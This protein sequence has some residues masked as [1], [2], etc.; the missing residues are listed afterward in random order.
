M[1]TQLKC[2]YPYA[3]AGIP[4]YWLVDPEQ[5]TIHVG[6]LSGTYTTGQ[7]VPAPTPAGFTP[8]VDD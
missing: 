5:R 4:E 8:F 1:D 2:R 7:A 3:P 6:M